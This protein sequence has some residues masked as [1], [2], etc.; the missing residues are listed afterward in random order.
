[1]SQG[2]LSLDDL[3]TRLVN[4]PRR[5]FNLPG[6]PETW[7]EVDPDATWEI[8]AEYTYT[9]C[10][11]TPFE[12]WSVKGRLRRATL[13]GREVF[14]DGEVLAPPGYGKNIRDQTKS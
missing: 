1:V 5:I 3:M 14:H 6:Q 13:R 12:G 8:R 4:N 2:R 11:W 10:A 7:I 9:R